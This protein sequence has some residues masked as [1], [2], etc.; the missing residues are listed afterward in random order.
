LY[1]AIPKA[2]RACP[3]PSQSSDA[4]LV[5]VRI[6]WRNRLTSVGQGIMASNKGKLKQNYFGG[7]SFGKVGGIFLVT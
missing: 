1:S 2:I 4:D 5:V 7:S 6:A 3:A